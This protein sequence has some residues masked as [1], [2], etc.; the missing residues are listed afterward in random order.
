MIQADA[1]GVLAGTF[2][3]PAGVPAGAKQVSFVGAGG[4]RGDGT[5]VGQGEQVIET[6]Q[7]LTQVVETR[8]DPLAQTFTLNGNTQI[9]GVDLWVMAKGAS[10]LVVQIRETTTGFPNQVVLAEARMQ[11]AD[12]VTTGYT[13]FAFPVPV[14]LRGGAE[15][16]LVLLC[17]DADTAVSIAELGKWDAGNGRWVTSQ[18]YQVGVL[19]SSSNAS[20]WTA[21]QDRDLAFRL[22]ACNFT[23]TTHTF[24]LGS[25]AVANATDLMLLALAETPAADTRVEYQLGLPGGETIKVA[26]GQPVQL[27]AAITGNVSVSATLTGTAQ[28]SP[29]LL[30][31]SQL[32]HGTVSSTADYVGRAVPAG[33]NVR[34][35]VIVDALLPAGAGLSMKVS[36]IDQGD[37]FVDV[38]FISSSPLD[39]GYQELSYEL[40]GV[41][42][43]MVRV[44]LIATGATAAR[45][46]VR[47]LRALVL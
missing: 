22:L 32:V 16:A 47:N 10:P 1:Q 9:G 24:A 13:R 36:G 3:V 37:T 30:P 8:F 23:E 19:L 20:T 40:T 17:N 18:P 5:F 45:P 25:V 14:A 4:S 15:Y 42:E 38:P 28:A 35:K 2:T 7:M 39:D 29:L 33:S 46:H 26:D 43:S 44:K 27:Q 11:P 21:H 12:I 31:G 41:N 34:V 6:R